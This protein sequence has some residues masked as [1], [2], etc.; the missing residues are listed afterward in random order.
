MAS[1]EAWVAVETSLAGIVL[2]RMDTDSGF[3]PWPFR[4]FVAGLAHADP[5]V[6]CSQNP[7]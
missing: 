6:A 1:G 2:E 7:W 5:E 3:L 4:S